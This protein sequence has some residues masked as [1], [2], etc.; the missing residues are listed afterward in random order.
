[1]LRIGRRMG[2]IAMS[3]VTGVFLADVFIRYESMEGNDV[4]VAIRYHRPLSY[5]GTDHLEQAV[6]LT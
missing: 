6:L 4:S 1:M 3:F 5:T 2:F